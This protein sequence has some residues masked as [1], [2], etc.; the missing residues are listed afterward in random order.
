MKL[1]GQREGKTRFL[2]NVNTQCFAIWGARFKIFK[3]LCAQSQ[4][5]YYFLWPQLTPLYKWLPDYISNLTS[6]LSSW[7]ESQNRRV[8]STS[9]LS[10]SKQNSWFLVPITSPSPLSLISNLMAP[11]STYPSLTLLFSSHSSKVM[12]SLIKS[13]LFYF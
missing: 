10:D 5:P 13:Y 9:V 4:T 12:H 8:T 11:F 6:L 3:S 2:I 1:K 7:L